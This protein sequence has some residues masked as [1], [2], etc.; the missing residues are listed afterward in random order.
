MA[1]SI[2]YIKMNSFVSRA[3]GFLFFALAL[4]LMS[5]VTIDNQVYGGQ[6]LLIVPIIGKVIRMI[7]F[8]DDFESKH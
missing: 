4:I 8:Q 7:D 3:F 2:F 6:A 1:D 5:V